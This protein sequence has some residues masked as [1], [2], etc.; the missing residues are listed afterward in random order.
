MKKFSAFVLAM[1]GATV[2]RAEA[3]IDQVIVRQQWPWST[4]IKVEYRISGAASPV[5]LGVEAWNG[6]VP[7]DS[8]K[9]H[10]AISG[11]LYGITGD[12]VG[13][14]TIDPVKAFGDSGYVA[15]ANFK[16][17]LT[18][19]ED[20]RANEVLYK[21]YDLTATSGTFPSTD[22]TRADLLNGKYGAV[23]TDFGKV[24]DG[25]S[26][27]LDNV[28]VWTGVTNNP[29]Y[30][31]TKLVMRKI[32]AGTFSMG[33]TGGNFGSTGNAEQVHDVTLTKDYFIGV[34]PVTQEQYRKLTRGS[35]S[36][37]GHAGDANPV[38]TALYTTFRSVV[39]NGI[40]ANLFGN[41]EVA[42]FPTEAQWEFACRAGTTSE[43]YT[44]N[45]LSS[46]NL[47]PIAWYSGNSENN[48]QEVGLKLPNAYGLYDM[49][50]N[51][52]EACRDYWT[53]NSNVPGYS[54][55]SAVT[56]PCVD[57]VQ[58]DTKDDI[59]NIRH[60]VRGG[61]FS[62]NNYNSTSAGRNGY[63]GGWNACGFRLAFTVTD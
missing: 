8:A 24:G 31:T 28:V 58:S 16:V 37:S 15:L 7:L 27:T 61:C 46:A 53:A 42:D 13:E 44:G 33:Q 35:W 11:T 47:D 25:F 63:A 10:E 59:G 29:A 23:E 17:R 45:A 50:G 20:P 1:L 2:L 39:T 6:G 41:V 43:L 18:V 34:F 55:G 54:T 49:V 56:N 9:L 30:K 3:V 51:V 57:T 38:E 36:G 4:D 12:V 62:L 26:T 14:F 60:V 32:P 40:S 5:S 22:V 21:I 52:Y 19:A 48:T